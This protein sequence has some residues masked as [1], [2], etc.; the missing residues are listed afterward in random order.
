MKQSITTTNNIP[1]VILSIYVN[2]C[3]KVQE[4]DRHDPQ[5]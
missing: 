1:W 4:N 2:D 5:L 3:L